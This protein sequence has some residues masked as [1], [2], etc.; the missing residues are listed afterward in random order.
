MHRLFLA[1]VPPEPI[2]DQLL[3]LMDGPESLRWQSEEQLHCTLRFVGEVERPIAEDLAGV[4]DRIRFDPFELRLCG[5][6]RFARRRGGALWA[7]VR[8]REPL[9][10]LAGRLDRLCQSVGLEPER[11]AYHPHLTLARWSGQQPDLQPWLQQHAGLTSEPW[12]VDRFVLVESTLTKNGA[13]YDA[14]ESYPRTDNYSGTRAS[15]WSGAG[16]LG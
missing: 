7:G 3:D 8:P 5:I 13:H 4:L 1:I 2:R 12:S 16:P 15:R 9:A 10:A 14:I 6:G 11:R